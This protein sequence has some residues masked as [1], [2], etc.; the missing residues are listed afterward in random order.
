MAID[1]D[2]LLEKVVS[3]VN[4]TSALSTVA[5]KVFFGLVKEGTARPYVRVSLVETVPTYAYV[6]T[7][8][9]ALVQISAFANTLASANDLGK[10]ISDAFHGSSLTL[11]GQTNVQS[12]K[13]GQKVLV[14]G[15]DAKNIVYHAAV[16][17]EFFVQT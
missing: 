1:F 9:R 10:A 14:D 12:V 11:S 15:K 6:A 7:L 16:Q 4:A 2:D 13:R 17:I 3:R 8:D 5:S